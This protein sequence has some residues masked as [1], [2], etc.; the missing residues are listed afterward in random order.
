MSDALKQGAMQIVRRLCEAGFEAYLVGGC[1]RDEQLGRPVKDYDIATSAHPDQVQ[2]LFERTVPTGLQHGTVTV[3]IG[4][5]PYEVTTFRREGGYEAFRR[6]TEVEYIESLTEDLQRR[7]FTMNAMAIDQSGDLIDPFDGLKDLE[8]GVLRCVGQAEER[9]GEDALRMMRC[10]RFASEYGLRVEQATWDALNSGIS[11]LRHIA[12]ERIRAEL[13]RMVGGS[14][15]NRALELLAESRA[16]R[17][18]KQE[19]LLSGLDKETEWP[20]L[21]RLMEMEHRLAFIYIRL[22]ADPADVEA[23]MIKLTFSR[24][25]METV[26][27]IVAAHTVLVSGLDDAKEWDEESYLRRRWIAAALTYGVSALRTLREIYLLESAPIRTDNVKVGRAVD[28]WR[29]L[30]PVWHEQMPV[31]ALAELAVGGKELMGHLGVKGGP[32]TGRLLHRLLE[33][34]ALGELPNDK[35]TLLAAA[36]EHYDK[37]QENDE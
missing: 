3:V 29:R 26:K 4:K 34:A 31:S 20:P 15:P 14:D 2:G 27:R 22:E 5:K 37:M 16:L 17:H 6:P 13:E 9:F 21:S 33:A 28:V 12:M 32:W 35:E 8:R 25:Q 10:L 24:Q 18:V 7:D 11:L 23:D 30:G 1:V 36:R 19:L